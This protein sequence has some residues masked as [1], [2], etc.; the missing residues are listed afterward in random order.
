MADN[1]NYVKAWYNETT[2]EGIIILRHYLKMNFA[3][4][5]CCSHSAKTA[6]DRSWWLCVVVSFAK[7]SRL[8]LETVEN[9]KRKEPIIRYEESYHQHNKGDSYR[10]RRLYLS[11]QTR[12]SGHLDVLG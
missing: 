3:G 11:V 5:H 7:L 9:I 10:H 12:T 2:S 6:A 4:E 1:C 8:I